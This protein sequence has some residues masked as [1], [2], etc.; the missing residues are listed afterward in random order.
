MVASGAVTIALT[1]TYQI[2]GL[3]SKDEDGKDQYETDPET[4]KK[5]PVMTSERSWTVTS[6]RVPQTQEDPTRTVSTLE[7][8]L[9]LVKT[10]FGNREILLDMLDEGLLGED[11][12]ISGWSIVG[13][14]EEIMLEDTSG[15]SSDLPMPKLVARKVRGRDNVSIVNVPITLAA[16]TVRS[17]ASKMV[18]TESTRYVYDRESQSYMPLD[19]VFSM[20]FTHGTTHLGKGQVVIDENEAGALHGALT[21]STKVS[22]RGY[23]WKEEVVDDNGNSKMVTMKGSY[24][25]NLPGQLRIAN[26]ASFTEVDEELSYFTDGSV[27]V[28]PAAA[29][30]RSSFSPEAP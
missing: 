4:G 25:V 23:S 8:G 27:T 16:V 1:D 2:P 19:P 9:K 3:I 13:V 12:S 15:V 6:Y 26:I 11:T 21:G 20:S 28:A 5:Y 29:V 30:L 17:L 14:Y 18:E 22:A 7:Q 24:F 10:R